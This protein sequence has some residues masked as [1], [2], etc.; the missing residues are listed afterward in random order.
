[1]NVPQCGCGRR[2]HAAHR[3]PRPR[4]TSAAATTRH[5]GRRDHAAHRPPPSSTA[6]GSSGRVARQA[7]RRAGREVGVDRT[8]LSHPAQF[9]PCLIDWSRMLKSSVLHYST[10]SNL[11]GF[12]DGAGEDPS[13]HVDS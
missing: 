2:D 6:P 7:A 3:P 13:C 8:N 9:T 11:N 5:I 10:R 12:R 4:G 1:V